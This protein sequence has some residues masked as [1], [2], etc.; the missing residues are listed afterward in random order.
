M[1]KKIIPFIHKD[2][3]KPLL[4]DRRWF[5]V[6]VDGIIGVGKSTLIANMKREL[7]QIIKES[8]TPYHVKVLQIDEPDHIWT[9]PCSELTSPFFLERMPQDEAQS[10]GGMSP[11]QHF[12][13]DE[14]KTAFEFQVIAFSTR[15]LST[16]QNL[17]KIM[18]ENM[19]DPLSFTIILCERSVFTDKEIFAG[20][21]TEK[22][23]FSS[24]AVAAYSM[25][26][27]FLC[28]PLLPF[29]DLNLYLNVPVDECIDR[30]NIRDRKSE[31]EEI[32]QSDFKEYESKLVHYYNEKMVRDKKRGVIVR[33][34]DWSDN[35]D[36]NSESKEKRISQ[37]C[38]QIYMMTVCYEK[39]KRYIKKADS[40]G[41]FVTPTYADLWI[42]LIAFVT[43]LAFII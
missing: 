28:E 42:A 18:K 22:G 26:H 13:H 1:S 7:E 34:I 9:K 25:F 4:D 2:A 36:I 5:C 32:D 11:L 15:A 29:E 33:S 24:V 8:N 14:K 41:F 38:E 37:L 21:H 17:F 27:D 10:G 35:T 12:Y 16:H 23:N 43:C 39:K 19:E 40:T 30:V 6:T 3:Y 31:T 20:V